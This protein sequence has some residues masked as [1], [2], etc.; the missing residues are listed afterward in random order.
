MIH[1]HGLPIS[2]DHACSAIMQAGHAMISFAHPDQLGLAA[3]ICQ[4]FVLDNGAFSAWR[5]GNPIANWE[6]Y[7]EWSLDAFSHPG[8]DWITIP[9]VIDGDELAND[10][11]MDWFVSKWI[12]YRKDFSSA[13][14]PVWHMHESFARL[15][16]LAAVFN[17]VAI[18]SS[19]KFSR[20]GTEDW[21]RQITSAIKS[22]SEDGRPTVK[23][24][25][26]RMLDVRVFTKLPLSSADSTNVA[27]NVGIDKQWTGSYRPPTKAARGQILR[28][29]IESVNSLPSLRD[30]ESMI[31]KEFF[32]E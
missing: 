4:S 29:R 16:R 31:Q 26:M 6:P 25:G 22:I 23:L 32:Y 12:C 2:P 27:R 7:L 15:Q 17:R 10:K 1:Y 20:V 28:Q 30:L 18:G 8:C 19:G 24:H 9:D 13:C 5:S 3:E 14:V 21:W 11:L